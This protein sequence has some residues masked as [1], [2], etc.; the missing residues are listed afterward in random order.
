MSTLTSDHVETQ[1]QLAA[2]AVRLGHLTDSSLKVAAAV[3][4]LAAIE[5]QNQA[6]DAKLND[7]ET[8]LRALE[9]NAWKV[10]GA[11]GV[12]AFAGPAIAKALGIL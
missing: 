4:K 5:A 7:H 6:R 2:I 8:R 10:A 12:V 11:L 9:V 3:D 1:R